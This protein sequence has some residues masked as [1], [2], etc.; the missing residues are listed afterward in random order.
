MI[1]NSYEVFFVSLGCAK[2][3]VDTEVMAGTLLDSGFMITGEM[4]DADI[5]L[6][7]TCSFIRDAR[8]EAELEIKDA[9]EWKKKK[10][11]RYLVVTGCLP[12][13]DVES[14]QKKYPKVI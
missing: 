11:S 5:V 9:L 8:E 3:F 14:L 10:K 4:E 1:N 6:V 12:Q 13:Q 7:N 2:N